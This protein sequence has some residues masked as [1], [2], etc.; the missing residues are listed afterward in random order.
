MPGTALGSGATSMNKTISALSAFTF[1]FGERDKK[2][3]IVIN[4]MEID[5]A[6]QGSIK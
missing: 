2:G 1:Y 3:H 6:G 5:Q 4:D